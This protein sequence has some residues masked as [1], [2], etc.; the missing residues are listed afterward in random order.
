M[1]EQYTEVLYHNYF[2]KS[3]YIKPVVFLL[4]L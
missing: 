4:S 3:L 2:K 1:F